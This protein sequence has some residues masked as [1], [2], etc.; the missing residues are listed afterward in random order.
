[1]STK[2]MSIEELEQLP[3]YEFTSP[4]ELQAI[5]DYEEEIAFQEEDEDSDRFEL[6]R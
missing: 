4:D 2:I 5:L 6:F 1:M 3:C